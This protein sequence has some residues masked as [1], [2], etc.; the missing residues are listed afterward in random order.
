[1]SDS[2]TD[3]IHLAIHHDGTDVSN[4]YIRMIMERFS[5][6]FS[7]VLIVSEDEISSFEEFDNLSVVSFIKP[8]NNNCQWLMLL[9][10]GEIPSLQ[11]MDNL[12]D[13]VLK[14]P[15]DTNVLFFP[16]VLCSIETGEMLEILEPISRIF[17]QK[18]QMKKTDMDEI[19]LED[20][21]IITFKADTKLQAQTQE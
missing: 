2:N 16:V 8:I 21:P 19:I 3:I 17:R 15:E 14:A 18:P 5:N 20:F 4:N 12:K 1:V 11:L 7:K 10:I 13:I 6:H 9:E